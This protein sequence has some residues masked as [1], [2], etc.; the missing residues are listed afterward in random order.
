[1]RG[2]SVM[3]NQVLAKIHDPSLRVYVVWLPILP[4]F[5]WEHAARR[6]NSRI[7][8]ARATRY[9]DPA[10]RIGEVY[11]AVLHLPKPMR[12]WDVYMAF[13]PDARW[14]DSVDQAPAPAFWMHQLGRRAPPDERLDGDRFAQAV[15]GLLAQAAKES[16]P[17]AQ[18]RRTFELVPVPCRGSVGSLGSLVPDSALPA[19]SRTTSPWGQDRHASP[20]AT[21]QVPSPEC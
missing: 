17:A 3:E 20:E 19:A 8:D 18:L 7:P 12:A 5:I 21:H 10:A 2:A 9:Y 4:R 13:G 6:E 16:R 1:L 15:S 11:A 14:P